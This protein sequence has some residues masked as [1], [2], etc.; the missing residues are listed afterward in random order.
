MP[1]SMALAQSAEESG[2]GTSLWFA[3]EGNALFGQRV[4]RSATG[5][6]P[7]LRPKGESFCPIF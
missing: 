1:A 3:H 2:W 5:M 4:W 7:R 6:K